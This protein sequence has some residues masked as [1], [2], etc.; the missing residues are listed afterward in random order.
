MAVHV[1]SGALA[2]RRM[3]ARCAYGRLKPGTRNRKRGD[4]TLEPRFEIVIGAPVEC[5]DGP[6]GHVRQV[7]LSPRQRRV[8]A[9]V[10]RAGFPPRDVAVPIEYIADADDRRVKLRLGCAELERLPPIDPSGSVARAK[11]SLGYGAD[12]ALA[13]IHGG[14]G[15][16]AARARVAA[17]LG[18][19]ARIAHQGDLDGETLPLRRGQP[20]WATDGR[21]GRVELLLLDPATQVCHF[22]FR[23][24]WLFGHDVIVPIDWV[25][26]IDERG[27]WL[28]VERAAL[29]R[30]PPYRPDSVIAAE[31]DQAL[32]DDEI[33]RR[34]DFET[35]GA[36]VRDGVVVLSGYAAT[37]M[38]RALAEHAARR[39]AG[40]QGVVNQIVTD[41]EVVSAVAQ[42]LARDPR[43]HAQQIFVASDHG[44]VTL[45]G[46][47]P[48][49]T[50][51][52]AAEEVAAGVGQVRAVVNMIEA[53][54]VV[55]VDEEQ[56]V[57]QPRVGQ[58][59]YATDTLVGR[60]ERVII[61]PRHR[62][63]TALVVHGEFLDAG[64][65]GP[66]TQ[67]DERPKLVR[68]VVIPIDAVRHVTVGGVFLNVGGI[69]AA[70]YP[71]FDPGDVVTPDAG[72]QPPYPYT[73]ADVLIDLGRAA[74]ARGDHHIANSGEILAIERTPDG[75]PI[76]Q[77]I[78]HG[79]PVLFRDGSVGTI[80]H[81][82]LDPASG[83]VRQIIVRADGSLTESAVI[84][85]D[86][87]RRI[88][89]TG[90]FV[91][92]GL[93][94]LTALPAA[95]AVGVRYPPQ[96]SQEQV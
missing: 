79:M 96:R 7:I 73:H 48:S 34:L 19:A 84:P 54:G 8:L 87:V 70:H 52:A 5:S 71:D 32:W 53:P 89:E 78:R 14:L 26:Q 58:E 44:V 51:R 90:V 49:A 4:R 23:K 28:V 2:A 72:W 12:E 38:S 10:V 25:R 50:I 30:L 88:D 65:A 18:A 9:L 61:S 39:I 80:D 6:F 77:Q 57:V 37:P 16:E 21:A 1:A 20:V 40:V 3:C 63:V 68:H 66:T 29:E 11:H 42:A 56:R 43:T 55:P 83:T 64:R 74:A 94:Q 47:V 82:W 62:R 93:Q 60:V 22:V 27:V 46:E 81:L 31:V 76:W 15:D 41:G 86:W 95:P 17:H 45:R 13:A 85:L 67:L 35:I 24:G 91:D 36:T 33:I 92:V 69:E 59:V 75:T